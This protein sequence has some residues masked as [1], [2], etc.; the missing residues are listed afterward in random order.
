MEASYVTWPALSA[1]TRLTFHTCRLTYLAAP[2]AAHVS[3]HNHVS[4][5]LIVQLDACAILSK[6]SRGS[7][8]HRV[9]GLHVPQSSG[10]A[11]G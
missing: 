10:G 7:H 3:H 6:G 4:R 2:T 5:F 1:S 11:A 9:R 8:I